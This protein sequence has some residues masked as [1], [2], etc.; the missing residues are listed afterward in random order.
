MRACNA[1]AMSAG[2]LAVA[3][4]FVAQDRARAEIVDPTAASTITVGSGAADRGV[5]RDGRVA[6][7]P[8]NPKVKWSQKLDAV[9]FAPVVDA[10]GVVILAG[11]SSESSIV[12]LGAQDGVP[13]VTKLS[14]ADADRIASTPI[15]LASGVRVVVTVAGFVIGLNPGGSQAFRVKLPISPDVASVGKA[16][17][18]PLPSG[19]FVVARRTDLFEL[20][21]HGAVVDRATLE[22][23]AGLAVRGNGEVVGLSPTAEL[24]GWRGGKVAHLL[25][26]F[27]EKGASTHCFG[28]GVAIDTRSKGER[29]VCVSEQRVETLDLATGQKTSLLDVAS[30]PGK[31]PFRTQAAVSG[32]GDLATV[33]AGGALYGFSAQGTDLGPFEVPGAAALTTGKDGGVMYPSVLGETAPLVAND[34]AIAWGSGDGVAIARA[35]LVSKVTRCGGYLGSSSAWLASAGP[36]TL[37]V[38]CPEGKVELWVDSP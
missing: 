33:L 13:R 35:G 9:Q 22:L 4:A 30:T 36:G 21:A 15:V 2:I 10:K 14:K 3:I 26:T 16:G 27:G 37:L 11:V 6:S 23:G 5:A 8:R 38:A 12:E 34:G 29:A 17:A 1:M 25:G 20:D 31:R 32:S 19:G 18:V 7:L 24:W 28:D